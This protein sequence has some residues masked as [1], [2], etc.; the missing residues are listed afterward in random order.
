[1]HVLSIWKPPQIIEEDEGR[2]GTLHPPQGT[3]MKE[4]NAK[5]I[6]NTKVTKQ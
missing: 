1:M 4:E 2:K 6:Q 5:K 3:Y